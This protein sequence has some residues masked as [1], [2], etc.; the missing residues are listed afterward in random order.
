MSDSPSRIVTHLPFRAGGSHYTSLATFQKIVETRELWL[1]H[2]AFLSDWTEGWSGG[3]LTAARFTSLARR[4]SFIPAA[5]PLW[6]RADEITKIEAHFYVVCACESGDT[7]S[8]WR[9][10]AENGTGVSININLEIIA[11]AIPATVHIGNC[12]YVRLSEQGVIAPDAFEELD[13]GFQERGLRWIL[14]TDPIHRN[15]DER[16]IS[17]AMEAITAFLRGGGIFLKDSTFEEE[18]ETRI[19]ILTSDAISQG[20]K[21][22]YRPTVRGLVPFVKADLSGT[23]GWLSSVVLG[24][25]ISDDENDRTVRDFLASRGFSRVFVSRSRAPYRPR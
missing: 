13:A 25:A 1:T 20:L 19:A 5:I 11:A 23:D 21:I 22:H 2:S 3:R 7:L 17:A 15:L 24:P 9:A 14:V 18:N 12:R 16:E 8:Q 6:S 10:Y 4:S